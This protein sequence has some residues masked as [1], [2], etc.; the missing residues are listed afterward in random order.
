M[1]ITELLKKDGV[2]LGVSAATQAEAIDELVDLQVTCGAVNDR[3]KYLQA[4][5]DREAQFSTAVGEGIA[6]PHAKTAAVSKAGLV[7]ITVPAGVDWKAPDGKPSDLI[8]LIAAPDTQANV[9]LEVLAKLSALLMHADFAAA[10]RAAKTPEEFLAA[11][12]KAEAE[13]DA[14]Q[15]A[16]EAKAAAAKAAREAAAAGAAAPAADTGLPQ[17]LAITACPTGIAHTYMAAENLEKVAEQMG[18]TIKV[19]T[20][21]S[22]GTKNALTA[23]EIAA[24]KGIIIA[25]DKGIELGR[26]NGK[27]LYSTNVSAGINDAEKLINIIMNGEAPICHA[28]GGAS[29]PAASGATES[30]GSTVYKHLMNGV[31]H[32]LP[33]V[34]GGG[35]LMAI[36]F[37][38]DQ[39]GMG[40]AS[41]GSSTPL[42]AFFNLVGNQAF[43]F[44]LPI[45]AGYISMSIADRPGLAPGFV[46]GWIAKQGY[47][48]GYLATAMDAEA[49]GALI[50]GGFIAA[51]FAGFAA[52]YI[53][54]GIEKACDKLPDSLEGIK[55]VL[56]YPLISIFLIGL[57]MLALNPIFGAI[58]AWLSNAL[59]GM[60][61][62][63]MVLLG[64]VVGGMMSVDMGG[65]F[66]KAAYVFGTAMLADGTSTGQII[67]ASVMVG[68]MVP[69]IAI[70]LSTTIFKNRW[71]SADRK[72]GVVNYIMGLSFITEGAIPYAA[73]DPGRVL[74]SCIIGSALAG[75]ISAAFG[76][77]SP[78]PH[79]GAWVIAVIG[80]PVMYLAA[81]AIGA[82]VACL[83]LSFLKKPL[84]AE[85]AGLAK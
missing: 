41:Y 83:I 25:A 17:V 46:G 50:S 64:A 30:L 74:P 3:A 22:V 6:I 53:T 23:E 10:L 70:A 65:P 57:V 66:N 36:S 48:L 2:K 21:G 35:I 4:V 49:Q 67:M 69:P 58:N 12:D 55:P 79:G 29:A 34:V 8:F 73:A 39:A 18:V 61:T 9:H 7:A 42:A 26:F 62:G 24:C 37:L 77:T 63:N 38:L 16:K 1:K 40:T 5:L 13:H 15:A 78:A 72:A 28:E 43:N 44:M 85:E 14:E 75:A 82:V 19:E 81:L 68:G 56:L 27:P 59:A 80:N 54:Y 11:I 60:G 71:S 76:C 45:L 32:M 52:G 33:F 20:Q 51:L 31:S 47:T 84:A